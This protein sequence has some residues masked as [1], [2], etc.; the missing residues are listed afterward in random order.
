MV[1]QVSVG[2]THVGCVVADG[3]RTCWMWG[4]QS[5]GCLGNGASAG[6]QLLPGASPPRHHHFL[7]HDAVYVR[8]G[9]GSALTASL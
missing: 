8:I 4:S 5:H 9:A 2:E 7:E 6:K 3:G 1:L